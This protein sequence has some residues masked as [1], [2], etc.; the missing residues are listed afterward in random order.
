MTDIDKNNVVADFCDV[1]PWNADLISFRS[2][3]SGAFPY[4]K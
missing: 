2:K 3:K 4:G 1:F